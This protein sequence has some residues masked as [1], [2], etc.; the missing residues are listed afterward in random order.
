MDLGWETEALI[1]FSYGH[2][3]FLFFP[4]SDMVWIV[5]NHP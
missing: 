3:N 4:G 5:V 2:V 1:M